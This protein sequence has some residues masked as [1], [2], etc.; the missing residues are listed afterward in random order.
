[1]TEQ[2]TMTYKGI[3]H[4]AYT[5]GKKYLVKQN[6]KGSCLIQNDFGGWVVWSNFGR[7]ISF[8]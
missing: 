2:F 7:S 4:T 1:M 8:K 6:S 5:N 3:P